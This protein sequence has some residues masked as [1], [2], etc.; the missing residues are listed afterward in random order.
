MSALSR[1]CAAH[2]PA[3][4]KP[5]CFRCWAPFRISLP[6][7]RRQTTC[8]SSS[9]SAALHKAMGGQRCYKNP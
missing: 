2:K 4:P 3:Q 9:Y 1:N 8:R 5:C 6:R 7:D